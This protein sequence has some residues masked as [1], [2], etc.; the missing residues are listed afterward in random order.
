MKH[1]IQLNESMISLLRNRGMNWSAT[2]QRPFD[3]KPVS[4]TSSIEGLKPKTFSQKKQLEFFDAF[5]ADPFRPISYCLVSAPNDSMA[6]LLAA[7][8]MQH[9]ILKAGSKTS[10]PL[11]VDLLGG[12]ENKIVQ[13]RIG[14][15]MLIL[16]NVGANSTQPKLE[17]LRD[18]IEVYS[19]KP[20]IV[21]A[22]GC[23]PYAFFTRFLFSP[24]H[25][26]A[27]MTTNVVKRN[28]EV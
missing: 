27:Y 3:F 5:L 14:V 1:R 17:K 24:I 10:L 26:L 28:V 7:Y 15:S 20:K 21:I 19:D 2:L 4:F 6:K 13:D 18:I 25:S 11:W 9:A 12:F 8:M 16:N 23:D 22:T